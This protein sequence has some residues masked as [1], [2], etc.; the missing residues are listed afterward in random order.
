MQQDNVLC[1]E[2][3]QVRSLAGPAYS[4]VWK[5]SVQ[6]QLAYITDGWTGEASVGEAR[7][8]A[9]GWN[10]LGLKAQHFCSYTPSSSSKTPQR[11]DAIFC[12]GL[13]VSAIRE[14]S[15]Q[16]YSD[17]FGRGAKRQGLTIVVYLRLTF[18][19]RRVEVENSPVL[20]VL[21]FN[22]QVW[23]YAA[24]VAMS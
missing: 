5:G 1:D 23:R 20:V 9:V 3:Q 17:V 11:C 14:R 8:S 2:A 19:F 6:S 12:E 15:V 16:S 24:R 18:G 21:I 13:K 22:L 7:S 10:G 4:M